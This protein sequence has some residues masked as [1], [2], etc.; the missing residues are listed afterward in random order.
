MKKRTNAQ[1]A[2][3]NRHAA[4]LLVI[5]VQRALFEKS[6]PIY[7]ADELLKNI[8]SLVDRA[9]RAGAAVFYVQHSDQTGLRAG[10][11]GWQLH[12]QLHPLDSDHI[13]H[14]CHASALQGTDLRQELESQ[15]ITSL[16]VTGLVTHGCVRATCLDAHKRGYQVILVEDGHSNFNKRAAELIQEWH[17]KLSER[18]IELKA[19]REI[20]F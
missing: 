15:R 4:A 16:V 7:Q 5:D 13:I 3:E 20:V 8:S 6:T 18:G 2:A 1:P 10:S 11:E 14:K 19:A 12:P 9:H 17:H